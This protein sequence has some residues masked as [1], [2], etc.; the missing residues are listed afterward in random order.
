MS[1]LTRMLSLLDL[2]SREHTSMSADEIASATGL[3][4]TTCYRYIK[5]LSG[6]GL[7][8]GIGGEFRLG[9]RII[10][11]DYRIRQ[12]DSLLNAG[13]DVLAQLTDALS[14]TGLLATI[15]DS[16]I[17]NI[18]EVGGTSAAPHLTYGR[19]TSVPIFKTSSSKV[20]LAC[21]PRARLRRLW[22]KH[23][24]DPDCLA[25]GANWLAFW[26]ALQAIKKNG[27]WISRSEID[28]AT[29]GIAAPIFYP[30]GEVAGSM[31]LRFLE[32]E[33]ALFDPV[34]LGNRIMAGADKISQLLK[35]PHRGAQ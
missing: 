11:L 24:Q 7:L 32:E 18:F 3:A 21:L 33:F 27:Y 34:A 25:I 31:T 20:I 8:V 15:Y 28:A 10:Q 6:A 30:S 14:A 22:L 19:G 9:P 12:S 2:F 5:E 35:E 23:E 13:T 4:R 16:E 29:V 1:S 26:H 17:I